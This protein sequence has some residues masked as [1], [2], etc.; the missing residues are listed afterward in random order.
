MVH[1]F[2]RELVRIRVRV[3]ELG[4]LV[5]VVRQVQALFF[6]RVVELVDGELFVTGVQRLD[7][8]FS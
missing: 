1:L 3:K 2:L 7:L 4:S 8:A 6:W 5:P